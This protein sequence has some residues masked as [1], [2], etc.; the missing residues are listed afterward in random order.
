MA[1]EQV[2]KC[3]VIDQ[4]QLPPGFPTH[5]H[6]AEFWENLG[7]V[8]ATFGFLEEIL[9]K[10]IFSFTATREYPEEELQAAY[11]AWL[12][13]LERALS[14]TLGSLITT[15]EGAVRAKQDATIPNL[16]ELVAD[17]RLAT[18]LRNVVCHGSWRLP[19]EQGRS[20]PFFVDRQRRIF[21]D[22]IDTQYLSDLQASVT[23]L[24]CD[25]I[26]TVTHMGYQFPGSQGPGVP[27]LDR[28]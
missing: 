9:G 21:E 24:A 17:L 4:D 25:V 26:N 27:I 22:H 18:R 14:D 15:Y 1:E 19:D 12:P 13:T 2:P 3:Y 20:L 11:D 5:V 28:N 23:K 7:R 8:V 16:D 10:A 6:S